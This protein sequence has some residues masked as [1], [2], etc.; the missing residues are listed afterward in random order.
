MTDQAFDP[1]EWHDHWVF[2][3][4]VEGRIA[5]RTTVERRWEGYYDAEWVYRWPDWVRDLREAVA[6]LKESPME[7]ARLHVFAHAVEDIGKGQLATITM[8][9]G[10]GHNEARRAH[11]SEDELVDKLDELYGEENRD[12]FGDYVASTE[13]EDWPVWPADGSAWFR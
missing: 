10:T 8:N 6:K 7:V 5:W 9:Y 4:I 1:R 2:F 13:D 11:M 12:P 3:R